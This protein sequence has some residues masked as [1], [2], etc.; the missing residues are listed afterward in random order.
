MGKKSKNKKEKL[1]KTD[2]YS[3]KSEET[4]LNIDANLK[5]SSSIETEN[6]EASSRESSQ[7]LAS[8][9]SKE[10]L[11]ASS[12]E[13]SASPSKEVLESLEVTSKEKLTTSKVPP[14]EAEKLAEE[15]P[16]KQAEEE[17]EK[18]AKEETYVMQM[19][20]LEKKMES[21]KS[22]EKIESPGANKNTENEKTDS[23]KETEINEKT[24]QNDEHLE[25]NKIEEN[26]LKTLNISKIPTEISKSES[27][28]A[29]FYDCQDNN[30][31]NS[32]QNFIFED[33][34][35][36]NDT[37]KIHD[38]DNK[39]AKNISRDEN[40][41][42]KSEPLPKDE[43]NHSKTRDNITTTEEISKNSDENLEKTDENLKK[44]NGNLEKADE[45]S[46]KNDEDLEKI[47]KTNENPE[48]I[49]K[50]D[51]NHEKIDE[52]L[53]ENDGNSKRVAE[54]LEKIDEK[55]T[56]NPEKSEKRDEN[57]R[58]SEKEI[59]KAASVDE[60]SLPICKDYSISKS[61]T[62]STSEENLKRLNYDDTISI[63]SQTV[64]V[65]DTVSLSSLT[66]SQNEKYDYDNGC[67]SRE[68]TPDSGTDKE[69]SHNEETPDSL[70]IPSTEATITSNDSGVFAAITKVGE[71]MKGKKWR[72]SKH[73]NDSNHSNTATPTGKH[74]NIGHKIDS[75]FGSKKRGDKESFRSRGKESSI[76]SADNT[77]LL[78][79]SA[80]INQP[81]TSQGVGGTN[82]N[83][84]V[85]NMT[86]EEVNAAFAEL[87][88]QMN[89][90]GEKLAA[91]LSDPDMAKKRKM[92]SQS[93]RLSMSARDVSKTPMD[94]IQ[95]MERVLNE[96]RN[97]LLKV[98][99]KDGL[100]KDMKVQLSVQ[101]VDWIKEFGN[102]GGITT[103]LRIM[104]NLIDC[105]RHSD[106]I[107]REEEAVVLLHDNV[108]CLKSVVNTWPGMFICFKKDS[109]MF[110][111]LVGTLSL[112]SRKPSVDYWESLK[113]ETI[114][115]LT[116][117]AFIN[118]DQF[119]VQG[120]EA[121]LKELTEEGKKRN[122]E[123]FQFIVD[124][125]RK[126]S[127]LDV[128]RK[129]LMLVNIILDVRDPED[130]STEEG[131]AAAEEAWQ[132]RMHWRS[133]FMRAGMY[134]CIEFFE[135]CSA[136]SVKAQYDTF[137]H[138]KE[139]DFGEL[140]ARFEQIKGEYE[141]IE[142]CFT[143]L[144]SSVKGT[145]SEL[146]FLSILQHMLLI[147]DDIVI[148]SNYFRLIENCIS[149]IVLPKTCVDPDFKGKFEFTQDVFQVLDSYD[150][151]DLAKQ[152]N[153]R[154][155]AATESKNEALAKQSQYYKKMQEFA[156]E[157]QK[158][159]E[160]IKNPQA[161]VPRP[162]SCNLPAP[163][164]FTDTSKALP[165]VTG[166]PPPPPGLPPITGGPPPPPP[167]P[168]LLPRVTG[169][170][171]PPPPPPPPP[172]GPR[173]SGPPPPPPPPPGALRAGGPPP[174]P[175]PPPPPGA[176]IGAGPP[177]PPGFPNLTISA[178]PEL[179]EYLRKKTRR[180]VDVNMKKIAWTSAT[181][182]P[183]QISKDSFWAQTAEDTLA[184]DS[185]FATLKAN[186]ATSRSQDAEGSDSGGSTLKAPLQKKKVKA[187]L[188]IQDDKVLQALAI[189]QGSC[190]IPLKEWRRCLL[191]IDDNILSAGTMQQLRNALPPAEILKKL[192]EMSPTKFNE[193]PE[194]EQFA[195]TMA[196]INA[197]PARLDS[198]I[199]MLRFNETLA[200]LKPG[201]SAVIEACDEVRSSAGFKMFLEIVLLVGN[202]MG[203][204]SKTY[205]DTFAFEMGALTKLS[206]TKD[207]NNSET[208][209]RYLVVHMGTQAKGQYAQF[210]MDD[211]LHIVAASRANAD[212]IGKGVGALR[213]SINKLENQL[214]SYTK[215]ESNDFFV[216]KLGPF[217]E[218]AKSE[219]EIVEKMYHTMNEKW[220]SLRKYYAFDP[221]KY[222]METFFND[223]KT[224]KEQYERTYRDI[225]KAQEMKQREAQ[226]IMRAPF[227]PLQPKTST[228]SPITRGVKI[229]GL[230]KNGKE[231][232]GVVDEIEKFLEEGYLKGAE[233]RTPKNAPRTR[234]GR[235]A[236]E[237]QRS[238]GPESIF[239]RDSPPKL[240]LPANAQVRVRRKG[241]PA[242]PVNAVDPK[243]PLTSPKENTRPLRPP[244]ENTD[245]ENLP[246][247]DDL[248]KR[249][250]QL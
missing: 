141:N 31:H 27:C 37:R 42:E 247:T 230:L 191:E 159:R 171:P 77:S 245:P 36:R 111:C 60:S 73:S 84:S 15:K 119:E 88:K 145:K 90:K 20:I 92:V 127:R 188:V 165:T 33:E 25:E 156:E 226:K 99:I 220:D 83:D 235:A 66:V 185:L 116:V 202:Y 67:S 29:D 218:K 144:L 117:V 79:E 140:V 158:L 178:S 55:L 161:P 153:K 8:P 249:L 63:C 87:L 139:A 154:L 181:I 177:P 214:K 70:S 248:L 137:I 151:T 233:R 206:D 250:N 110:A 54:N 231:A 179:P 133:E 168:G 180:P 74:F 199:F 56:K 12:R 213:N 35:N 187:P 118:D 2:E 103:M 96:P 240:E 28:D 4:Q 166:G 162:T 6:S 205:K 228:A 39:N 122:C 129:S 210:P 58:K 131:K 76:H 75:M 52:N 71:A 38:T 157:T 221:K 200:D 241:Q 85:K 61:I 68:M 223:M 64:S 21:E 80:C 10:Q 134:D 160:H 108:K 246:A 152:F 182:R 130:T 23:E 175:P 40:N 93:Q 227:K 232:A 204:S 219:C 189:L 225:E 94:I 186:F 208:L 13:T 155:E 81:Q 123:R 215:Q 7:P 45:N 47:E 184:S 128:V 183:N 135:K 201:I 146:S 102:Q 72:K 100:M 125:M 78:S 82:G 195:A 48:R 113:Y 148:R 234:A 169:G 136:E 22:N 104:R 16:E 121:L 190:K 239:P 236:I 132:M 57:E 120:R 50:I 138:N 41:P 243:A 109:K 114:S 198:I 9:H 237:R 34:K 11:E 143:L 211:F 3:P 149:E 101:K 1:K 197:L 26:T 65:A 216:E 53:K 30:P 176:K 46:K 106:C 19:D 59:E 193:M 124:C 142:D 203:H 18:Q 150:D 112:A 207:I 164:A 43:E 238:R 244:K 229:D 194:G 51:E 170:P 107:E 209:L 32:E 91:L 69:C 97:D 217:M 89:I 242:V 98:L 212:E 222:T 86:D 14:K 105:L 24:H 62:P 173:M 163:T 196:S 224:F 147:P 172:G 192:K 167:P 5:A 126:S 17:A 115:L 95:R 44:N 174:P 49:E